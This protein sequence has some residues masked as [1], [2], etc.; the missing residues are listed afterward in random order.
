VVNPPHLPKILV[1]IT[2]TI[3]VAIVR[4]LSYRVQP[5]FVSAVLEPD[6][7][8][9]CNHAVQVYSRSELFFRSERPPL[10]RAFRS[11]K[12]LRYAHP[13][14]PIDALLRSLPGVPDRNRSLDSF[15]SL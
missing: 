11:G 8:D 12:H 10:G 4:P 3:A 14:N 7:V 1:P 2:P 9:W 13:D 5:R 6:E 15:L